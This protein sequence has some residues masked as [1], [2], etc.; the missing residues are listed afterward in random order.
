MGKWLLAAVLACGSLGGCGGQKLK[1]AGVE[2]SADEILFVNDTPENTY[3]IT[4]VGVI[5]TDF[6]LRGS[7]RKAVKVA[8]DAASL[9]VNIERTEG[10]IGRSRF[11][12]LANPGETVRIFVEHDSFLD[13]DEV[14]VEVG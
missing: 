7:T 6:T 2:G 9:K 12:V 3:H 8:Q 10:E 5:N 4:V 14:K 11:S 13:R 1:D